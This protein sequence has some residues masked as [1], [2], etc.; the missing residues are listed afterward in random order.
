MAH[1][2][3]RQTIP[4]LCCVNTLALKHFLLT[5]KAENER[6][7]FVKKSLSTESL[8][9]IVETRF[10]D[11]MPVYCKMEKKSVKCAHMID[12]VNLR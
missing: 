9:I 10:E 11:Q 4:A 5:T 12:S 2:C 6:V 3:V 1:S 8:Q 7:I